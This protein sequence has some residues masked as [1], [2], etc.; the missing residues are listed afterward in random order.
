MAKF[1]GI[2]NEKSKD[3]TYVNTDKI[4]SFYVMSGAVDKDYPYKLV[5]RYGVDGGAEGDVGADMTFSFKEEK[6]VNDVITNI[7]LKHGDL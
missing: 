7:L 6:T 4:I 1:V 2:Y 5:I 3:K